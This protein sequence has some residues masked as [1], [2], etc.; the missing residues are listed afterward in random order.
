MA[1]KVELAAFLKEQN[2]ADCIIEKFERESIDGESFLELTDHDLTNMNIK[3]SE[4]K[5]LM[6]LIKQCHS[7][8]SQL[9]Q[10]PPVCSQYS[11]HVVESKYLIMVSLILKEYI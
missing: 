7:K 8:E 4:R 1:S 11:E 9:L 5:R 2:I 10:P 6:K 3:F